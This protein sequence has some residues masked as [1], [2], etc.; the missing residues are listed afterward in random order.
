DFGTSSGFPACP[1]SEGVSD[2]ACFLTEALVAMTGPRFGITSTHVLQ[3]RF[4]DVKWFSRLP[5]F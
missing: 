2:L 4:R 3:G 1:V 5:G